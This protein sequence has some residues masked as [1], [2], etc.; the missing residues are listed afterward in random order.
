MHMRKDDID[1]LND[2]IKITIDSVDGYR[3]AAEDADNGRFESIFF[4]RANERDHVV[5]RLRNQVRQ[6]GG[7]PADSGSLIAGSHQ[8]FMGFTGPDDCAVLK[9]VE[10]G[11]GHLK[12]CYESAL[13]GNDLSNDSKQLVAECYDSVK[14]GHD[15]MR[16]LQH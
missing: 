10:R 7:E 1:T 8:M 9:E 4:D 3:A 13:F 15:Q 12:V 5:E 14:Q 6:L 16:H 11:E 2:L